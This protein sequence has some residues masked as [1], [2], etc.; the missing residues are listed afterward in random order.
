MH[1]GLLHS[2][3]KST[4]NDPGRNTKPGENTYLDCANWQKVVV[5]TICVLAIGLNKTKKAPNC[6]KTLSFINKYKCPFYLHCC[7]LLLV[8][9]SRVIIHLCDW[10]FILHPP[11]SPLTPEVARGRERIRK[12]G[13]L[14]GGRER[15]RRPVCWFARWQHSRLG[16]PFPNPQ[17]LINHPTGRQPIPLFKETVALDI[18]Y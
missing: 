7:W 4:V 17:L 1:C 18:S 10:S 2:P 8:R 15:Q 3:C 14:S 11:P 13:D 5:L 6:V 12:P 9:F 16:H